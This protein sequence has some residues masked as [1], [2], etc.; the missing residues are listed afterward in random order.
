MTSKYDYIF[1]EYKKRISELEQYIEH[2]NNFLDK[3]VSSNQ[4]KNYVK[5]KKEKILE[6][7]KERQA[8]IDELLEKISKGKIEE[9]VKANIK[10]KEQLLDNRLKLRQTKKDNLNKQ[11]KEKKDN[12][13]NQHNLIKKEERTDKFRHKEYNKSYYYFQNLSATIPNYILNNLKEMP[14]N[15]GYYWKGIALY[16][17][18]PAEK[19][20]PT[21]LF[22]KDKNGLLIIHEWKEKTY[23]IYHKKG[24]NRKYLHKSSIRKNIVTPNFFIN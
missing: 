16:G 11:Q 21:I 7:N 1:K 24:Q 3:I 20:N 5:V 4:E 23:N 17:E 10:E 8:E 15:K 9:S 2:D 6:K 13:Y 14:E 19:G 22:E 12:Y 18:L